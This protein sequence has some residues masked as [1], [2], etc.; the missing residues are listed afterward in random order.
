[1]AQGADSVSWPVSTLSGVTGGL[2]ADDAGRLAGLEVLRIIPEPTAAAIAYGLD[3]ASAAVAST[4]LVFDLGGGTLDVSVLRLEG[5]HFNT[6]AIAGNTELGGEDFTAALLSHMARVGFATL[7]DLP[8]FPQATSTCSC[9]NAKAGNAAAQAGQSCQTRVLPSHCLLQVV[10]DKHTEHAKEV[11]ESPKLL[12]RLRQRCELAKRQLSYAKQ[13]SMVVEG[14]L[15][16][17][18]FEASLTRAKFENLTAQAFQRCISLTKE[19]LERAALST[20][21]VSVMLADNRTCPCLPP[22]AWLAAA[23]VMHCA[24]HAPSV[25]AM[26][27]LPPSEHFQGHADRHSADGGR[28]LAHPQGAAAAPRALP[29]AA[30]ALYPS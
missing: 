21:Q 17:E 23:G 13:T 7:E 9:P 24:L 5:Q 6:L 28:Q 11:S 8:R 2:N 19:A 12:L 26:H 14:L 16:G 29:A 3:R 10:K 4:V 30:Q 1:M 22:G 27:L 20:E 15:G 25:L 18:D